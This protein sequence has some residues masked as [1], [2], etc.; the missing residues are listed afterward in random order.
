[1]R[2]EIRFPDNVVIQVP[3]SF[4]I[5]LRNEK[6]HEDDVYIDGWTFFSQYIWMDGNICLFLFGNKRTMERIFIKIVTQ[7]DS[8]SVYRE[9]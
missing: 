8:T 2:P 7:M 6:V 5:L 9:P 4:P 1:M 3:S